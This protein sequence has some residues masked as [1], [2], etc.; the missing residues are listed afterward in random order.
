MH[1]STTPLKQLLEQ[2]REQLVAFEGKKRFYRRDFQRHV[3]QAAVNLNQLPH[4]DFLLFADNTYDFAVNFIGLIITGKNIVLTANTKPDWLKSIR[5]SYQVVISDSSDEDHL[6]V[7][8]YLNDDSHT[9][10]QATPDNDS[11][12]NSILQSATLANT[13][14]SST[15]QFYTS[16]SSSQPKAISKNLTQLLLEA[17]TLDKLFGAGIQNSKVFAT[18]SHHHIYG[19]IFRLLWPLLYKKPF[20][21]STL[22]YPEEL[23][24]ASQRYSDICLISSPA[25]LSRHDKQL[26]DMTLTQCFSSGSLLSLKAAQLTQQQ[27]NL[28]PVEV[29]GSTETGGIGY[30]TQANNN[31]AWN[32]FP[33]VT[34]AVN[35]EGRAELSSP[36]ISAPEYL[37]DKIKIVGEEQFQLL[38]RTDRVV[39]IEEKRVSL[40]ALEQTVKQA[41]LV[42]DCKVVVIQQHRTFI[43]AVVELSDS[44]QAFLNKHSKHMLNQQ[45]KNLLDSKFE[46]VAIPR[47]WRYF[48]HLPYN[49]Q[50]KLPVDTLIALF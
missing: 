24:A 8:H 26:A 7:T 40:D 50:G 4:Q 34:I 29:F 36:Y 10:E 35:E 22:L 20:N 16:G 38:G 46:A 43:G 31:T 3:S 28:Y 23:V 39:K 2:D 42:N 25:F 12:R 14:A 6:S 37:D 45:L 15:V 30:R 9:P 33:G 44:G 47:K 49:S 17:S 1:D 11:L 48:D 27:F 13:I 18:V 21:T 41:E 19:L 32:L 5:Q